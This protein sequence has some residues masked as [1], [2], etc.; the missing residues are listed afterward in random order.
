MIAPE[1]VKILSANHAIS[2]YCGGRIFTDSA[3]I[4]THCPYIVAASEDSMEED[5]IIAEFKIEIN[6]YDYNEDKRPTYDASRRIKDIL[7][8]EAFLWDVEDGAEYSALR[9]WF[10]G[11]EFFR[12]SDSKLSRIYMR[13]TARAIDNI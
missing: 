1:I 7:D 6:I 9:V 5:S 10:E 2:L 3:P 8:F 12:E 13:F 11:R 4:G